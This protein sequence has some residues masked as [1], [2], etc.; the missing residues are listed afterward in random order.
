MFEIGWDQ[1]AGLRSDM[2]FGSAGLVPVV[3]PAQP[4]RAY[5]LLC[6][7]AL[8]VNALGREAVIIDAS[9]TEA[10]Q[11]RGN[12][13]S[14]LGLLHALQDPG[15]AGLA[16]P[17]D[18]ADWLVMPGALGL[19][20]LQHTA[21]AGGAQVAIARLLAPFS[22]SALVLLFAPPQAL[23]ALLAGTKARALVPVLAMAQGSIDAYGALKLLVGAGLKPVLA[24]LADDEQ[25]GVPSLA[26]VLESVADCAQRHLGLRAEIWNEHSWGQRALESA[27]T[28]QGSGQ[29]Q[30]W[31]R[32]ATANDAQGFAQ[33]AAMTLT[34]WS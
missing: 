11:R 5:E 25:P 2:A 9:A 23:I 32:A 16:R 27:L 8:Q 3:C 28:R 15:I 10:T 30:P 31:Q 6:R 1:A 14:H 4:A 13:G 24:P 12:D 29:T 17:G 19:Q 21:Q 33:Q 26:Q 22:S 7:L 20:A 34:P 18:G